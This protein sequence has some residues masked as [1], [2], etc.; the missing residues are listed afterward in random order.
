VVGSRAFIALMTIFCGF[1]RM[2]EQPLNI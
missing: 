1:S 2:T